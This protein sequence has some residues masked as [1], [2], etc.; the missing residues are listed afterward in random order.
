MRKE[1]MKAMQNEIKTAEDILKTCREIYKKHPELRENVLIT[2]ELSKKHI[3][4]TKKDISE[5]KSRVGVKV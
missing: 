3:E 1:L 5:L 2:A 4:R